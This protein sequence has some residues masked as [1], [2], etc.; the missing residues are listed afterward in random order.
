MIVAKF[1]GTSVASATAIPATADIVR[2]RLSARPVVV[3]SALAGVT[4]ALLAAAEQ[5][6]AGQLLL[7]VQAVEGSGPGISPRP[8]RCLVRPDRRPRSCA[9]MSVLCDDLASL[10]EAL[11]VLGHL[12]PRS[13]DAIAATGEMLSTLLV[14]A[15]YRAPVCPPCRRCASR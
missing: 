12:T 9:E 3:V 7:A 13:L 4:N 6:T 11:S 5:A 10:P 14:V 8:K 2:G 15:A 1:G